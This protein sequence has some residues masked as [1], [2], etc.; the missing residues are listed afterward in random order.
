MEAGAADAELIEDGGAAEIL[1]GL[2]LCSA[3]SSCCREN[4]DP[5][6]RANLRRKRSQA[7]RAM[8]RRRGRPRRVCERCRGSD[9]HPNCP[10]VPSDARA[11]ARRCIH[12]ARVSRR[13]RISEISWHCVFHRV[14]NDSFPS[15][16]AIHAPVTAFDMLPMRAGAS[17]LASKPREQDRPARN[18]DHRDRRLRLVLLHAGRRTRYCERSCRRRKRHWCGLGS[19]ARCTQQ[20]QPFQREKCMPTCYRVTPMRVQPA[21]IVTGTPRVQ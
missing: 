1:V 5:G 13:A 15:P 17:G 20:R 12:Q 3:C 19:R 6:S 18:L 21:A 14:V 9:R 4:A 11:V 16:M 8:H 2:P 10:E 7:A